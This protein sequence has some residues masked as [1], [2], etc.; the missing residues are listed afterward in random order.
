MLLRRFSKWVR[1]W[2]A[3]LLP[4]L[5]QPLRVSSQIVILSVCPHV[6][7]TWNPPTLSLNKIPDRF[8]PPVIFVPLIVLTMIPLSVIPMH[9][10]DMCYSRRG[11][12]PHSASRPPFFIIEWLWAWSFLYHCFCFL[13]YKMVTDQTVHYIELYDWQLER[14]EGCRRKKYSQTSDML[15]EES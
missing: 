5:C 2:N 8:M 1:G 6:M 9:F 13:K 3:R 11:E 14:N 15:P 10:T 4:A 7:L 12:N